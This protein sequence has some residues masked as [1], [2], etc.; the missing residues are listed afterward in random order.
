MQG[1]GGSKEKPGEATSQRER[2]GRWRKVNALVPLCTHSFTQQTS[3]AHLTCARGLGMKLVSQPTVWE[4]R[5]TQ[6]QAFTT[7]QEGPA[8]CFGSTEEGG[9]K[10]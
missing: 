4:G 9:S 1:G 5:Q 6:R 10:A 3:A 8:R 7:L 2:H